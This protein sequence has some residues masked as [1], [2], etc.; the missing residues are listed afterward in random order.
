MVGEIDAC[1]CAWCW[2]GCE[3]RASKFW[4]FLQTTNKCKRI[5]F[6]HPL[7]SILL[8]PSSVQPTVVP[9]QSRAPQSWIARW[10][11]ARK[12]H[13]RLQSRPLSDGW[14]RLE[15]TRAACRTIWTQ[16]RATNKRTTTTTILIYRGEENETIVERHRHLL[17]VMWYW[18]VS[19]QLMA[20]IPFL[21]SVGITKKKNKNN[22]NNMEMPN[23]ILILSLIFN[24]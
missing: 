20:T 4:K 3:F 12:I 9:G 17:A 16:S 23:I 13:F 10:N 2:C 14:W 21:C 8:H 1:C 15:M 7:I 5:F 6:Y 11:L 24:F 22:E 18:S 19:K